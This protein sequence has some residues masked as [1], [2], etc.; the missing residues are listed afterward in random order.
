EVL[1][2]LLDEGESGGIPEGGGS[3]VAEHH[4]V[5]VGDA[6]ELAETILNALHQVLHRSLPVGG[7]EKFGAHSREVLQ[8]FGSNL[9]WAAAESSV[10]GQEFSRNCERHSRNT[11]GAPA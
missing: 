1:R 2:A 5:A 4:L 3:A 6:E 10:S 9:G 8:L 11:T 7:S